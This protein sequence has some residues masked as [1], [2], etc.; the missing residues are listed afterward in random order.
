MNIRSF[1]KV[2]NNIANKMKKSA[3]KKYIGH[4]KGFAG[5]EH[6]GNIYER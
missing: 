6:G 2:Q 4:A 3:D 5:K 1:K